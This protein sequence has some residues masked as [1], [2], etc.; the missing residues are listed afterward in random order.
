MS[1]TE[2]EINKKKIC[3]HPYPEIKCYKCNGIFCYDCCG[4]T[5]MDNV[6]A[7]LNRGDYMLCPHCGKDICQE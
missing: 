7:T 2:V 1:M 6:Q 5:N 4:E 3:N